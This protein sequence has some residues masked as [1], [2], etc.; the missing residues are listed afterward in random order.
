MAGRAHT[1]ALCASALAV[2]VL[3]APAAARTPRL[4]TGST[5]Y[6]RLVH[7]RIGGHMK[8]TIALTAQ[9]RKR[10]GRAVR[11]RVLD[12]TCTTLGRSV[13][14]FTKSHQS[15][16]FVSSI[17]RPGRVPYH[18]LLDR[19]ADFCDVGLAR[20]IIT[21]H[22]ASTTSEP[23]SPIDSVALTQKG[24]AYLDEDRVTQR[25]VSVLDAAAQ[26][27]HRDRAGEF[28]P[29][30]KI[31]AAFA[32]KVVAL[33]SADDSPPTGVVGFFSDGGQH[34]EVVAISALR[35]RLFIDSN[36]GVLSTNAQEHMFRVI[37]GDVAILPGS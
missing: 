24:A 3:A 19:H 7:L 18:T 31:V 30:A 6:V 13:Q 23:G 21:R 36:G 11:R 32:R 26:Y 25:M 35:R 20:L 9:G 1:H 4:R 27:A 28:P 15:S 34:A 2:L 14:G 10:L 12:A 22:S 33:G 16:E 8:L 5:R 37:R 17:G 29:A